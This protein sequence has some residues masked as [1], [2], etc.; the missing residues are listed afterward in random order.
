MAQ[1]DR[2]VCKLADPGAIH[3]RCGRRSTCAS[4]RYHHEGGGWFPWTV[5]FV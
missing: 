2:D 4:R 1:G 3:E 5:T